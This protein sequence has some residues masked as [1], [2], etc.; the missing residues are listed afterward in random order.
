M[1]TQWRRATR[2]TQLEY[3]VGLYGSLPDGDLTWLDETSV[4]ATSEEEAKGIAKAIFKDFGRNVDAG[5][6][7]VERSR[8]LSPKEQAETKG[9]ST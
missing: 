7:V 8:P 4:D 1:I 6:I 2:S 9:A 5:K 3:T